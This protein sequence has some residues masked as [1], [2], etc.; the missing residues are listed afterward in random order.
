LKLTEKYIH[1]ILKSYIPVAEGIAKTFGSFC[2]VVLHDLTDVSSSIVAIFNGH[3]TSR[4]V[5]SPLTDLGLRL[6]KKGQQGNDMWINYANE[7][8]KGK[9]IKSSSMMI[10][11]ENDRVIGCLCINLDLGYLNVSKSLLEELLSIDDKKEKHESFPLSISELERN[12][13]N[14][15]IK[16]VG[17]PI[18]LMDKEQKVEFI[19]HLNEMGLFLIK[20]SVQH[21]AELLNVS[22]F[23]IYNYLDKKK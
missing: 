4:D 11:D 21:I 2:E 17:K 13:I 7:S 5:G 3:V 12:M 23:T 9:E 15:G 6:I 22:K 8:V 14:E 10:R 18:Q 1:P 16:K 20:G 19:H